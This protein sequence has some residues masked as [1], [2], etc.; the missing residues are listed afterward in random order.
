MNYFYVDKTLRNVSEDVSQYIKHSWVQPSKCLVHWDDKTTD[1]L[2]GGDHEKR[3]AVIVSDVKEI[4]L[5]IVPSIGTQL[6][7]KYGSTASSA[8]NKELDTLK[9]IHKIYSIPHSVKLMQRVVLVFFY[10]NMT[11][12]FFLRM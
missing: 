3:I 5:V 2:D 12:K 8:I 6:K 10:R 11:D 9:S 7:G 1:F 4:K